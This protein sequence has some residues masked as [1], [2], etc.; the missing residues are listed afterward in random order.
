MNRFVEKK[1]IGHNQIKEKKFILG[2]SGEG[3][4][5]KVDPEDSY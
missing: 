4:G 1:H 3:E 2:E 5:I